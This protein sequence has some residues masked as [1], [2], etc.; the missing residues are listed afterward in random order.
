[1]IAYLFLP[2]NAARPYQTVVYF[3]ISPAL[4]TRSSENLVD[5]ERIDFII[6]S[7]R[8][9]VYPVYKST[10]ERGDGLLSDRPNTSTLFRDHVIQWY[11]DF[12][13]TVDYLETRS[14]ID[15]GKLAYYGTSWG[16]VM[17]AIIPAL[18]KRL[19]VSILVVGGFFQQRT[20]AE[21][22]QINFAPRVTI[23]VLMLNGQYDYIFPPETSQLPLFRLFNTPEKD[24][25][26]VLFDTGHSIPR[27]ELIRLALEWLDHYLGPVKTN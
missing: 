9:V 18:E 10:Y 4:R 8:A 15:A 7:G 1:V 14:D 6:R 25:R 23:P 27:N 2:Q 21:V 26:H 20:L 16:A 11:K 13:R 19:K 17:G 12:A 22:E 24:K 5:M 3:P